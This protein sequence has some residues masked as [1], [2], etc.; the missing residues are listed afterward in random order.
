MMHTTYA[1]ICRA[2]LKTELYHQDPDHSE[3]AF[4]GPVFNKST[5]L[6]ALAPPFRNRSA[7][8]R[9]STDTDSTITKRSRWFMSV[10]LSA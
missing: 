8:H 4:P 1:G 5:S 9:R 3:K 10:H 6:R 7:S 2:T